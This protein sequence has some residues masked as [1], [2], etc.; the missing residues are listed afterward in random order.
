VQGSLISTKVAPHKVTHSLRAQG[1]AYEQGVNVRGRVG[2]AGYGCSQ[3]AR[4]Q[5]THSRRACTCTK[6]SEGCAIVAPH[7]RTH[8]LQS[9]RRVK[10][11][12]TVRP[13]LSCPTRTRHLH[14][15]ITTAE[16]HTPTPRNRFH[17]HDFTDLVECLAVCAAGCQVWPHHSEP[18]KQVLKNT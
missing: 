17:T 9:R 7:Q 8:S 18:T 4:H 14:L 5:H 10:V 1:T 6:A 15:C 2:C 13:P 3:G 11:L 16:Y 12:L